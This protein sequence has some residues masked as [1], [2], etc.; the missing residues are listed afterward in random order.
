MITRRDVRDM[1]NMM[2]RLEDNW[3]YIR[4]RKFNCYQCYEINDNVKV[5]SPLY[6]SSIGYEEYDNFG[7]WCT[8]AVN[9]YNFLS[10]Y[11]IYFLIFNF[12]V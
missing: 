6:Y 11:F 2:I 4:I 8:V 5:N 12:V 3:N 9:R 10:I 7:Y 1:R